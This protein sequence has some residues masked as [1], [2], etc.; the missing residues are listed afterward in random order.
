MS[1]SNDDVMFQIG[2]MEH[3]QTKNRLEA[4]AKSIEDYQLKMTSGVESIGK[5][6]TSVKES[7]TGVTDQIRL[8]RDA[9][10]KAAADI[11]T[12]MSQVRAEMSNRL[13]QIVDVE[14]NF[15]VPQNV[16]VPREAPARVPA[17]GG[18]GGDVPAPKAPVKDPIDDFDDMPA[19]LKRVFAELNDV[20]ESEAKVLNDTLEAKIAAIPTSVE[21]MT[22]E[23]KDAYQNMILASSEAYA[24]MAA[25]LD[26]YVSKHGT[27]HEKI[28]ANIKRAEDTLHGYKESQKAAAEAVDQA[29]MKGLRSTIL[30]A[31]GIA[32]IGLM[33]E[34]ST[35]KFLQSMAVIQGVFDIFEGGADLLEAFANGY[36]AVG[37]ATDAA[38]KVKLVEQAMQAE[39]FAQMKAYHLA[40][41]QEATA[42]NIATAA[43]Q[44]LSASRGVGGGVAGAATGVATNA[45]GGAVQGVAAGAAGRGVGAAVG[46]AA[47]GVA[48]G[49]AGTALATGGAAATVGIVSTVAAAGA[50]IG[51]V[52]LVLAELVE[53]VTGQNNK[54]KS[55]TQKIAGY[56][57]SFMVGA[58]RMTGMFEKTDSAGV[59]L[60]Q[61]FSGAVDK[62]ADSVPVVGK[63]IKQLNVFGDMAGAAASQASLE[64][65]QRRTKRDSADNAWFYEEADIRRDAA[66]QTGMN[67]FKADAERRRVLA[68]SVGGFDAQIMSE[69]NN[70]TDASMRKSR[71]QKVIDDFNVGV[72]V[73]PQQLATARKE[74]VDFQSEVDRALAKQQEIVSAKEG[75]QLSVELD[76]QKQAMAQLAKE[77]ARIA[78]M[79]SG[80][81]GTQEELNDAIDM[82]RSLNEQIV[83]SQEKQKQIQLQSAQ[84]RIGLERE[85]QAN[86][87]SQIDMQTAQ[88]DK[89]E[90]QSRSAAGNFAKMGDLEKELAKKAFEQAQAKGAG[91]LSDQQKD[92]LR[93]VGTAEAIRMADEGDQ[94]EAQKFGFNQT[95]GD[96]IEQ[97]RKMI[98]QS[99]KQLE[100]DLQVSYDTTVN[101][102][103]DTAQIVDQVAKKA[104]EIIME[105]N[106]YIAAEIQRETKATITAGREKNMIERQVKP[107]AK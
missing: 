45:V 101:V 6:A 96:S 60:A 15:Q 46:G 27:T 100:A 50:A 13:K 84:E 81:V 95:F 94:A 35:Q 77:E 5:A 86:L 102:Q 91:S 59:K 80:Q 36:K 42:A 31:K 17:G 97:E 103:M 79:K 73:D 71:A 66:A 70:I 53:I 33:S 54:Q 58:L 21:N 69:Q 29:T 30:M 57:A 39:Q 89:L 34:E 99:R 1:D 75:Q 3:P 38:N 67:Q 93:Q 18:G 40:L 25:D 55:L 52:G 9:S 61:G 64:R 26:G 83:A 32:E 19:H 104:G 24:D 63:L 14:V 105:N 98:E 12:A 37:K 48:G 43:N 2:V 74:V 62:L 85:V 106:E 72:S 11:R 68:S 41:L 90:E 107:P 56:E 78:E 4:L 49:A 51:A 76:I 28:V 7:L 92:L 10:V 65:M 47:A 16:P 87:R 88:M 20:A 8:Y 23:L 22:R 44:R 82:A